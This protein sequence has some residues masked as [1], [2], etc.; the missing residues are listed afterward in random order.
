MAS[1]SSVFSVTE[2]RRT[3]AGVLVDTPVVFRWDADTHSAPIEEIAMPYHVGTVREEYGDRVVEQVLTTTPQPFQ[4]RGAWD[5]K[6]GGAGFAQATYD[7]FQKLVARASLV[8]IE[9]ERLSATGLITDL[10]PTYKHRT[11]TEWELTFSPHWLGAE[12]ASVRPGR[13]VNPVAKPMREHAAAV[14]AAVAELDGFL[15]DAS[16]VPLTSGLLSDVGKA[17][18]SMTATS[19]QIQAAT[20]AG[21]ETEATQKLLAVASMFSTLRGSAQNLI[22]TTAQA[23]SDVTV[24]FDSVMETLDF[25]TWTRDTRAHA[26]LMILDSDE[27]EAD[28]RARAQAA[29]LAVHRPSVGESWY[30]ISQR[31]YGTP[32]EWRRI[33]DFNDLSSLELDGT[34]ELLIPAR[35]A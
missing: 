29:P 23:R 4:L 11:R 24:A 30:Q 25:E 12:N 33:Y 22:D 3:G 8:R 10:L 35:S 5:D 16:A 20:S 1:G 18:D 32:N 21:L 9:F 2:L 31:Y 34:E 19:A 13:I 17:I 26:N 6:H 27:A 7:E 28:M 14:E 15:D